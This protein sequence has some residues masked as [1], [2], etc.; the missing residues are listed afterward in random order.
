MSNADLGVKGFQ[1]FSAMTLAAQ[2]QITSFRSRHEL[3]PL[4][5]RNLMIAFNSTL[6][7]IMRNRDN[8]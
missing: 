2:A 1:T 7:L 6:I 3:K 8:I 5:H 4:A